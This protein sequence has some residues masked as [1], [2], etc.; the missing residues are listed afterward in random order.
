MIPNGGQ[1]STSNE[2]GGNVTKQNQVASAEM[3]ADVSKIIEEAK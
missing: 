3:E 1:V 2:D